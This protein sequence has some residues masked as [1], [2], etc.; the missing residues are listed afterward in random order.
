[1]H[2]FSL[3]FLVALVAAT[4]ARVWLSLRHMQHVGAHRDEVP[5]A[6]AAEIPAASHRTAAD[7]TIAKGRLDLVEVPL[8]ALVVLLLTFGGGFAWIDGL[9]RTQLGDGLLQGVALIGA[10]VFLTSAISLPASIYRTFVIEQRF[11]FNKMTP[12]MFIGD[13][14]RSALLGSALGLPLLA[15][16]LW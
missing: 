10:V 5:T 16:V 1:M 7:Y 6:F 11:G 3:L 4:A 15:A 12:A 2:P 14:V 13:L 9:L 8:D